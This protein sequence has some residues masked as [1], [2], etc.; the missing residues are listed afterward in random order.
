MTYVSG[1]LGSKDSV[2]PEL[3]RIDGFDPT[4][5]TLKIT[6]PNSAEDAVLHIEDFQNN[7]GCALRVGTQVVAVLNGVSADQMDQA[8]LHF[9][10]E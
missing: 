6:L 7:Q 1:D 10:F 5:E 9:E 3:A 2:S 8:C 4:T